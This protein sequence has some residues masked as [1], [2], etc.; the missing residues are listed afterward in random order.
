MRALASVNQEE[1][2]G[3]LLRNGSIIRERCGDMDK[4]AAAILMIEHRFE[5]SK[6]CAV[7]TIYRDLD[8]AP[9]DAICVCAYM[10]K[11]MGEEEYCNSTI[12]FELAVC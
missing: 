4:G 3:W 1:G 9:H 2:W 6:S 12:G 10:L 11:S 8:N 5:Q 7:Q